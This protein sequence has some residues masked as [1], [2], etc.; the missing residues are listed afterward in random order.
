MSS[1]AQQIDCNRQQ[2]LVSHICTQSCQQA[3]GLRCDI[4]MCVTLAPNR[5]PCIDWYD[6]AAL[7][8]L[9]ILQ[10]ITFDKSLRTAQYA[11]EFAMLNNRKKVTAVHKANIMKVRWVGV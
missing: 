10:I 1:E 3:H 6:F 11:F 9:P 2:S 4:P 7:C 5:T 8:L